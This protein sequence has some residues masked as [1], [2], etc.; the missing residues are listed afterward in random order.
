MDN[1]ASEKTPSATVT[2]NQNVPMGPPPLEPP[3][4]P[5]NQ[6]LTSRGISRHHSSLMRSFGVLV[7]KIRAEDFDTWSVLEINMRR[8]R[9]LELWAKI[10]ESHWNEID[11]VTSEEAVEELELRLNDI[12]EEYFGICLRMEHRLNELAPP[13]VEGSV[14]SG[15][16]YDARENRAVNVQVQMPVSEA[17]IKNTWGK[18]DG[19]LLNWLSFRDKFLA[20]VHNK[21]EIADSYKHSYLQNS[22]EG[23]AAGLVGK[24]GLSDGSYQDAWDRI[25]EHYNKK[26]RLRRAYLE[27][28]FQL[29]QIQGIPTQNELQQLANVTHETIRQLKALEVPVEH[30][31]LIFVHHLHSLLD[32]ETAKQWELQRKTEDPTILELLEFLEKQAD[33]LSSMEFG[34]LSGINVTVDSK[35]VKHNSRDRVRSVARASTSDKLEKSYKCDGCGSYKHPIYDC[36]EFNSLSR[37]ARIKFAVERNLCLNCL[38]GGHR[39]EK[40]ISTRCGYTQCAEDPL[41][42]SK[43][44]PYKWQ[45]YQYAQP[46]EFKKPNP[47]KRE[48]EKKPQ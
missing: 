9:L 27:R 10:N 6:L 5:M 23:K 30:W 15:S 34:K 21:T 47:V 4:V 2:T 17:N 37:T 12:Q 13:P 41:H 25:M 46:S 31:D 48:N 43:L 32:A 35:G 8:E 33:A 16:G 42:N 19:N 29:K 22:L 18:Y 44:C 14:A 20:A 3:E 36:P 24:W 28:F 26:Y 40:C 45:R 38:R 11:A 1:T 39:K 7:Q